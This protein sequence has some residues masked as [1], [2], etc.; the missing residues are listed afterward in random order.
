MPRNAFRADQVVTDL[1]ETS[2]YR[3]VKN[4]SKSTS[5]VAASTAVV[6]TDKVSIKAACCASDKL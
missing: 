5:S 2:T 4:H 6:S 1:A 3:S